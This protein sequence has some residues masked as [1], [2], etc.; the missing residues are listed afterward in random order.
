MFKY[1]FLC[2]SN[3]AKHKYNN[4]QLSLPNQTENFFHTKRGLSNDKSWTG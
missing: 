4:F 1:V 3:F 2:R